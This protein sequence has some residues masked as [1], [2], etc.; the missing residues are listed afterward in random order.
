MALAAAV[1]L[2]IVACRPFRKRL[3]KGSRHSAQQSKRT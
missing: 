3:P 2:S 1:D